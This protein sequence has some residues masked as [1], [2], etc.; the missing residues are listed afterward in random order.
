M[1][2]KRTMVQVE[3]ICGA[4]RQYIK[5]GMSENWYVCMSDQYYVW[6]G[7]HCN[8]STT[9]GRHTAKLRVL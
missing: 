4:N 9:S 5:S 1:T 2:H 3:R 6:P 7:Y 8:I